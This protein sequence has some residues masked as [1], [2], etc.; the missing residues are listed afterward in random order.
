MRTDGCTDRRMEIGRV[1]AG[2]QKCLEMV[3]S[4]YILLYAK[5]LSTFTLFE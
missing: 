5:D 1:F 2:L 4:C 3:G